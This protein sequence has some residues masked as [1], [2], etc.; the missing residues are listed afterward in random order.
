MLWQ[1]TGGG[2][3]ATA[4]IYTAWPVPTGARES[5]ITM[6]NCGRAARLS[7]WV[8]SGDETQKNSPYSA[9]A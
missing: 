7:E 1:G 8:A 5:K 3:L 4:E 2:G 6:A 9:V